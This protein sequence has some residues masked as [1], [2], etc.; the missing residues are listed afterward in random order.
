MSSELD[1]YDSRVNHIE[2]VDGIATI[3]FS[4]AYIHKSGGKHGRGSG[5]DWSQEA[6]LIILDA[7]ASTPLPT[8]PNTIAEGYLEIGGIKHE[9]IPLP[10]KRKV[11]A[12]LWLLF[13]DGAHVEVIGEKPVIEL[14]GRP[15]FL[16]EN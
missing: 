8:L 3:H 6:R 16:D 14:L 4:Y 15:I 9:L 13:T 1:L 12:K 5:T 10:F 11:A 7:S 2:L